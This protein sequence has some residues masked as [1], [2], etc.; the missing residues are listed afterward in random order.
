MA[1]RAGRAALRQTV[2]EAQAP[3]PGADRRA[4]EDALEV[5]GRLSRGEGRRAQ[6]RRRRRRHRPGGD[7]ARR[8]H[9][10]R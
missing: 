3:H 5:R 1:R 6:G 8:D 7:P 9:A 2:V 4:H 10:E